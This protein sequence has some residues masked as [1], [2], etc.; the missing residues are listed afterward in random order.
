MKSYSSVKTTR[1]FAPG[2]STIYK[3]NPWHSMSVNKKHKKLFGISK[4]VYISEYNSLFKKKIL[5]NVKSNMANNKN[6]FASAFFRTG[7]EGK[8]TEHK[9]SQMSILLASNFWAFRHPIA[10]PGA[11]QIKRSKAYYKNYQKNLSNVLLWF[12]GMNRSTFLSLCKEAFYW[13]KL[14]HNTSF[15]LFFDSLLPNLILKSGFTKNVYSA[16]KSLVQHQSILVQHHRLI[17]WSAFC[18]NA[19]H[20]APQTNMFFVKKHFFAKNHY[21]F[22][23]SIIKNLNYSHI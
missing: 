20:A 10:V 21:S 9:S 19:N 8:G 13:N 16:K 4:K 3:T 18:K 1:M 23:K 6:Q 15:A 5:Y 12:G 17:N 22:Q 2:L 7:A 11:I 14:Y